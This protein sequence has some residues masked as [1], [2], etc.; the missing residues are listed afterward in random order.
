MAAAWN[1]IVDWTRVNA[2]SALASAAGALMGLLFTW[3]ISVPAQNWPEVGLALVAAR[4]L[5][6]RCFLGIWL[7]TFLTA[8][9]AVVRP[10]GR[11]PPLL[12]QLVVSGIL[13]GQIILAAQLLHTSRHLNPLDT[14][15]GVLQLLTAGLV[16]GIAGNLVHVAMGLI[17]DLPFAE[18]VTLFAYRLSKF[19][20]GVLLVAPLAFM[21][22]YERR[23]RLPRAVWA[24]ILPILAV[25]VFA[26]LLASTN[27]LGF[28]QAYQQMMILLV[29]PL[30]LWVSLRAESWGGPISVFVASLVPVWGTLRGWSAFGVPTSTTAEILT[31]LY[32]VTVAITTLTVGAVLKERGTALKQLVEAKSDLEAKV[33]SRTRDL[34]RERDFGSAIFDSIGALIFVHHKDGRMVRI[35]RTAQEFVGK[36]PEEVIGKAYWELG[37]IPEEE[38]PVVRA[39]LQSDNP[40]GE[41]HMIAHDGTRRLFEWTNTR[42]QGGTSDDDD[43]FIISIGIDITDRRRAQEEAM[44]AIRARDLFLSVASHELR[45][46]LTTLQLQLQSLQ[47]TVDRMPDLPGEIPNRLRLALRQTRRIGDLIN[48]LLDVS[49]IMHGRLLPERTEVDLARVAQEV[50]DRYRVALEQSGSELT[51]RGLDEEICGYWD[52]LRIDQVIDNLLSNAIKYG[53]GNPIELAIERDED[54]ARIVVADQGIGISRADQKRIFDRFERAVSARY[55]GGFGLGLWITRQVVEAHGGTIHVESELGKGSVFTVELPLRAT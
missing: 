9:V 44:E 48:E 28:F 10:T 30:T 14:R 19:I 42:L 41:N 26:T 6:P 31:H 39:R 50:V 38:L 22:H 1:T 13:T 18:I 21:I 25:L 29:L 36:S 34:R 27:F 54:R 49:R 17:F 5:G 24:E 46:P 16:A 11:L 51:V 15:R 43:D 45:T 8:D 47:R 37:I 2:L 3:G 53:E 20:S 52:P 7:V 33:E 32:L 40:V 12:L 4:L 35:N 55:Y 23:P